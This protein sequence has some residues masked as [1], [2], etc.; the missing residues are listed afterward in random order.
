MV[1]FHRK[2]VRILSVVF[3]IVHFEDR[4][5][6]V[7]VVNPVGGQFWMRV[8][9]VCFAVARISF[10]VRIVHLCRH[11]RN[12]T[13]LLV[14]SPSNTAIYRC[15]LRDSFYEKF[16]FIFFPVPLFLSDFD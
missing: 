10:R 5:V 9:A 11:V 3:V 13:F 6:S 1:S 16:S 7:P 2:S 8:V 15:E 4:V 12:R 14:E